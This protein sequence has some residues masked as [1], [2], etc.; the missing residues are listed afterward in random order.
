MINNRAATGG[1]GLIIILLTVA[2]FIF[3][4][5]FAVTYI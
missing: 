2:V 3:S 5:I 4:I 1:L